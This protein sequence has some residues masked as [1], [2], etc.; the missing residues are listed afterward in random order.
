MPG[1]GDV[2]NFDVGIGDLTEHYSSEDYFVEKYD[3]STDDDRQ[4]YPPENCEYIA[5][6]QSKNFPTCNSVHELDLMGTR[7]GHGILLGGG[8]WR[9]AWDVMDEAVVVDP[10]KKEGKTGE[11]KVILKMLHIGL[12]FH[13]PAL[14]HARIDALAMERLTGSPHV[15]LAHQFCSQSVVTE[16]ADGDTAALVKSK[17]LSKLD[18]LKI[19]RDV[20]LAVADMHGIDGLQRPALVHN[21]INSANVVTKDGKLKLN[22]FNIGMLMTYD[23]T[24]GDSCGFPVRYA[25]AQWRSPEEVIAARKDTPRPVKWMTEKIDVY[26]MGNIFYGALTTR[27]PWNWLDGRPSEEQRIERILKGERPNIP[28]KLSKSNKPEYKALLQAIDMCFT[29]DPNKRPSSREVADFLTAKV[30]EIEG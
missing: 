29:F 26:S 8:S 30:K 23:R 18:R 10:E 28:S 19:A 25:N 17:K 4:V 22:D 1:E 7:T 27:T 16:R 14:E 6:W 15:V 9:Q 11:G 12:S 2:V 5:E 21:D 3:I 13:R 24:T 20:A